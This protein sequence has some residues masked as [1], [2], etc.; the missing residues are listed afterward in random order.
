MEFDVGVVCV[1]FA[2]CGMAWQGCCLRSRVLLL[3]LC[4]CI[5]IWALLTRFGRFIGFLLRIPIVLVLVVI[6]SEEM[7]VYNGAGSDR[8]HKSDYI[9]SSFSGLQDMD[10]F[11][12]TNS[13]GYRTFL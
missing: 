5:F 11:P 4:G 1:A 10:Q 13:Q 6:V 3:V 9:F 8:Y 12:S 7:D 2:L